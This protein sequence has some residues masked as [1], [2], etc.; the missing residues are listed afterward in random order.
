MGWTTTRCE[1]NQAKKF[2]KQEFESE[3]EHGSW[4]VL[5]QAQ[6]GNV[7]YLKMS[8][9][10]KKTNKTDIFVMVVLTNWNNEDYWFNFGYK[11]ME[12][13]T[14]PFYYNCPLRL[15]E[16]LT[17]S[18][19]TGMAWRQK[20]REYHARRRAKPKVGQRIKFAKPLKFNFGGGLGWREYGTF[21]V[22]KYK[23]SG[24]AYRPVG[25]NAYL[26]CRIT[27]I[28]DREFE[29]VSQSEAA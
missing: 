8:H 29:I 6:V 22:I 19:E 11:E 17:E 14:G 12:D 16:G 28:E 21:D 25:D 13:C 27:K 18:N 4:L 5:D 7:H 26:T 15:L 10:D 23:K 20:V 24:I 1:P 2:L 9:L 3:N